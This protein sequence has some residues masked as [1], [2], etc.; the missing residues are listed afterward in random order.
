[1]YLFYFAEFANCSGKIIGL[2]RNKQFV[3]SIEAGEDCGVLLDRT[4]FYAE[5][6]GQIYDEGYMIKEGDEVIT[7]I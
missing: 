6:G 3:Q 2:R 4:C 5:Q 1:L 7:Y